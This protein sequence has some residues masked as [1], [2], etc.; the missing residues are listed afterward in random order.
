VF[1]IKKTATGYAKT[2]TVLVSFTGATGGG[3]YGSLIADAAGDLFGTTNAAYGD[4]SVFEIKK[5]AKGYASAP[6]TLVSF[7]G[8]DGA[9]PNGSLIADAA[10][11]LFGT[12]SAGGAN[13]DGTVFKI[14]KTATG[15]AK[16]PTT[17]ANFTGANGSTPEASLST[18]AAGDLF[19]TASVGGANGDG[20]VFEI[21]NSGF[22]VSPSPVAVFTQAMAS[23]APGGTG[24]A[25]PSTVASGNQA[26]ALLSLPHG[27]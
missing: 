15:Y 12:S 3:L 19:G 1:E 13:G 22:V 21:T 5:T 6:T 24:A 10:G 2:P 9:N 27:A 20:T 25:S 7:T 16:A 8:I 26:P 4:G 11:N 18:D 14:A 17:L 23:H